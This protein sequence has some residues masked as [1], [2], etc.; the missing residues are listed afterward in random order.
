MSKTTAIK[1][2]AALVTVVYLAFFIRDGLPVRE[3]LAPYGAA[4]SVVTLAWLAFDR[5]LWRLPLLRQHVAHRPLLDGTW[6][7]TLTPQS[8][9]P[10]T[11]EPWPADGDV[12]LVIK[13]DYSTVHACL[14]TRNGSSQTISTKLERGADGAYALYSVYRFEPQLGGRE[15]NPI[16]N[17]TLKVNVTDGAAPRLIGEYWTDRETIGL[18]ELTERS[19]RRAHGR[20]DAPKLFAEPHLP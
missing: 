18:L 5:W 2:A 4:V 16:H 14:H 9:N 6:R 11:G 13:Q 10:A 15:T 20:A 8:K 3:A 19:P 17:G 7:G 1:A 12:Y